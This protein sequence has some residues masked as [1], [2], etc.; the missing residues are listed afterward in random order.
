LIQVDLI[1]N[2]WEI[3]GDSQGSILYFVRF[4]D[5]EEIMPAVAPVALSSK[6]A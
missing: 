3:I 6:L 4:G 1:G 5:E 2:T